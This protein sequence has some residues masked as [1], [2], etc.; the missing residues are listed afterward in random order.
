MTTESESES[1]Y[2]VC[3]Y[4]GTKFQ[5]SRRERYP[6]TKRLPN[7]FGFRASNFVAA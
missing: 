3:V 1:E 7:D 2:G 4:L 5:L 6:K